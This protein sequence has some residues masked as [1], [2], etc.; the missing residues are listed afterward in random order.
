VHIK[1]T[2]KIEIKMC[3]E[4]RKLYG[5]VRMTVN[6]IKVYEFKMTIKIKGEGT[7]FKSRCPK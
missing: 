6:F 5:K 4:E 1:H 7:L 3:W 2:K